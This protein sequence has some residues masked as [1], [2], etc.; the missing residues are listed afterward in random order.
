MTSYRIEIKLCPHCDGKSPLLECISS[1]TFGAQ[2]YT[3]GCVVGPM[4][5]F[6]SALM[7]CQR[8]R[9]HQWREDVPTMKSMSDRD[10]GSLFDRTPESYKNRYPELGSPQP[11]FTAHYEDALRQELWET[12]AQEKY[13]RIRAWWSF[14]NGYREQTTEKFNLSSEQEANLLKLLQLL[15]KDN[16]E[17]SIMKAEVFRELGQF[18]ECIK[19]LNQPFDIK[20]LPAVN[21]IK[22]LANCKKRYVGMIEQPS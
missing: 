4:H 1:N 2:A 17:T 5:D 11:F 16:P 14:N 12:E 3:D 19:Q 7:T 21:T 18:D 10:Y 20:Y 13:I 15:N 8:C 6:G 9:R 22:K